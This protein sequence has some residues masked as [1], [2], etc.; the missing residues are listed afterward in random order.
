MDVAMGV[1]GIRD[2]GKLFLRVFSSLR[3]VADD[4]SGVDEQRPPSARRLL[5]V[6]RP[7]EMWAGSAG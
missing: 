5:L 1:A 3:V 2:H 4:S 6:S 7:V